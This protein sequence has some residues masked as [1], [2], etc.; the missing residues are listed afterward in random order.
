MQQQRQQR[1][2]AADNDD[3]AL[4]G[5]AEV[6][7]IAAWLRSGEWQHAL[8]AQRPQLLA[9][10]QARVAALCGV[11]ARA[12][13]HAS[14]SWR[15]V[16]ACWPAWRASLQHDTEVVMEYALGL[17][18]AWLAAA[19]AGVAAACRDLLATASPHV[20][21]LTAATTAAV[22]AARQDA[23][24]LRQAMEE[25]VQAATARP[26]PARPP[27]RPTPPP[28]QQQPPTKHAAGDEARL[29][30]AGSKGAKV[31]VACGGLFW[32]GG[33]VTAN[34]KSNSNSSN[35]GA[36]ATLQQLQDNMTAQSDA[37]L[38]SQHERP[39]RWKAPQRR[40][41][42]DDVVSRAL[43]RGS[44][45]GSSVAQP[46]GGP[47]RLLHHGRRQ[48]QRQQQQ[49]NAAP[50]FGLDL[51]GLSAAPGAMAAAAQRSLTAA[52]GTMAGAAQRGVTGLNAAPEAMVA[53]AQ[54]GVT[55]LVSNSQAVAAR[56]AEQCRNVLAAPLQLAR[57]PQV[58]LM[59]G[60]VLCTCLLEGGGCW[61]L[62]C[63]P[64]A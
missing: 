33:S 50:L 42:A 2:G 62:V 15:H 59:C 25:R 38:Y 35:Q 53:A 34:A 1:P 60:S 51:T 39:R 5:L 16:L 41:W 24:R 63:Q 54:R 64:A 61:G 52:P 49:H 21:P 36:L 48:Q 7:G 58:R 43:A 13:A 27:P 12:Y 10:L 22:R 23:Q 9:A 20:A 46:Q 37:L 31:E 57:A 29:S 17:L 32:F 45:P 40:G 26:A 3:A 11:L 56:G 6:Q 4:P 47:W 19:R 28:L 30:T 8:A 55:G 18:P 44:M 14:A